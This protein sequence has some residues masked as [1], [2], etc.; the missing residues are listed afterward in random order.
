MPETAR[1]QRGRPKAFDDK[2]DQNTVRSLDRAMTV[3]EGLSRD[4]KKG[5]WAAFLVS[6]L[7]L[8]LLC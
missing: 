7:L 6:L 4:E 5:L 3:L 8:V 2:T 1:R